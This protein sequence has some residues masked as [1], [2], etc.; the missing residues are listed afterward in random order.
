MAYTSTAMLCAKD[1]L[2]P[3]STTT[4]ISLITVLFVFLF[5]LITISAIVLNNK[6][7]RTR[8]ALIAAIVGFLLALVSVLYGGGEGLYYFGIVLLFIS[9]WLNGSLPW[10]IRSF[11]KRTNVPAG[12]FLRR[13]SL[14]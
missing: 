13:S 9:V 5:G 8:G 12:N 3:G 10:L 1:G 11:S 2:I 7:R 14:F 6:G 4:H